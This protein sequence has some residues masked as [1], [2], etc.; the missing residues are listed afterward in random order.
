MVHWIKAL[1]HFLDQ[2]HVFVVPSSFLSMWDMSMSG[3]G[4]LIV[5]DQEQARRHPLVFLQQTKKQVVPQNCRCFGDLKV[6]S[7]YDNSLKTIK[8]TSEA[9]R[10]ESHLVIKVLCSCCLEVLD[11]L[12]GQAKQLAWGHIF[13]IC[14]WIWILYDFVFF[15]LRKRCFL[16]MSR[17]PASIPNVFRFC[18]MHRALLCFAFSPLVQAVSCI[19]ILLHLRIFRSLLRCAKNRKAGEKRQYSQDEKCV[20]DMVRRDCP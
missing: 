17:R 18:S 1:F 16:S 7:T 14:E 6:S 13:E 12:Y 11:T 20:R 8:N 2:L 10:L 15:P 3:V 9:R 19:C 4:V 5:F